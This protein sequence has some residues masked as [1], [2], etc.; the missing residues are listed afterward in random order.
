MLR[1]VLGRSGTG[2]TQYLNKL[3]T[4]FA[5]S[6][7]EKL[8]MIV[9]DQ[10]SFETEKSFLKS[11]GP[12]LCRNIKVLGFS[13]LCDYVFSE[14]GYKTAN[15]IDD[16]T[17][18]IIMSMAI[19]QVSDNLEL[20]SKQKSSLTELMT[21]SYR[22]CQKC[23][24]TADMLK[25]TAVTVPEQSLRQKL[26]ETALILEA[27]E[28]IIANTYIDPCENLNR[29]FEILCETPVFEDYI[30]AV[31]SFSGFTAQQYRVLECLM[32]NSADFYV[33]L[34]LE[35]ANH[36]TNS[37]FAITKE[38]RLKFTSIAEKLAVQIAPV[39]VLDKNY[40]IKSPELLH[41][42]NNLVLDKLDEYGE[43]P[44]D[45]SIVNAPDV[46]Q[47]ID[48]VANTINS[49]VM[50]E[51]L[52]YREIAVICHDSNAYST[53]IASAFEKNR[54]PCFMDY[55]EDIFIKPIVRLVCSCIKAVTNGFEREDVLTILKTGLTENTVEDISAFE[56]YLFTWNLNRKD[57]LSEF[58][59]NPDGLKG[60]FTQDDKDNLN[61]L[62]Q[63]RKSVIC[64]LVAFK[65]KSK[66]A[67]GEKITGNLYELLL[68]LKADK[69][70]IKMYESLE[71]SGKTELAAQQIR[72]WNILM[73]VLDKM[74]AVLNKFK[75]SLKRY[76]ELLSMQFENEK[77]SEIP[78][79]V[80]C[81]RFGDAQRIRLDSDTKAVFVIGFNRGE[82]PP[83]PSVTGVFT[84]TERKRLSLCQLPFRDSAE[85]IANHEK[86]L[87]Y[88]CLSSAS[89][90]LYIVFHSTDIS[91][92][93]AGPSDYVFS[94]LK[95]FP[96]I[97]IKETALLT[98]ESKLWSEQSAFD[99]CAQNYKSDSEFEKSLKNYFSAN[100]KYA[101]SLATINGIISNKPIKIMNP[102]IAQRLFGKTMNLSASR[103]EKYS[104]C[105]FQYFCT[106]GLKASLPRPAKIDA[107]EF[108]T[109]SH[110][111][112]EKFLKI[113]PK[114]VLPD[115]SDEK[116]TDD[117]KKIYIQYAKENL[118]GLGDKSN[119]FL[120]LYKRLEDNSFI[121]IKHLISE[122]SQS[123]FVPVDF[124]LEIGGDIPA[125]TVKL[126]QGRSVCIYGSVDRVDVMEKDGS[127][128]IRVIDYKTGV[129]EFS[130]TDIL[131]GINLQMLIYLCAIEKNGAERYGENTV[132][133]G[134]LYMYSTASPQNF[135][136]NT[137]E[138][139]IR[140]KLESKL[141][142]NGLVLNDIS[143]VE[144][145]DKSGSG[146]YIPVKVKSGLPY[147]SKSLVDLEQMG[148]IF[149]SIDKTIT[150]MAENLYSGNISAVPVKG[151]HHDGC[152]YC[153]YDSVC[154]Y[155]DGES[156][157]KFA[158]DL[159]DSDALKR[160]CK[161]PDPE[162][163]N[164]E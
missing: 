42:E 87:A 14:V 110:Y 128:Y 129:K 133:A 6:G 51:N 108:G 85:E 59:R 162:E 44:A 15:T 77:I 124:E 97:K 131:W 52:R 88:T 153:P 76:G 55:P 119:S 84:E 73:Q 41:L 30:I 102:E 142:M 68:N 138:D 156:P 78:Q 121:I 103:I 36:S 16:G 157:Y 154:N 137:D 18:K 114:E 111:V 95:M 115:L 118:G 134:I 101:D 107:L 100:P 53:L 99:Y 62:E 22:E 19:E 81:V 98:V 46:Y 37:V 96:K 48:Y 125:Y 147:S 7:S 9:P 71:S 94:L 89:Q 143:V 69:M 123:K 91:G 23:T 126:P 54:I 120:N 74:S 38:T 144:G 79:S 39:V 66:D 17:R 26:N 1:F 132:P 57:F 63:V 155:V 127:K 161:E 82:F 80:D 135:E 5:K 160:I 109:I 49:L 105:P 40:R 67:D 151:K 20:F 29:V 117:I 83:V 24:I 60:D 31:D 122:L 159:K 75:P 27:Y 149:K 34:N 43:T 10:S 8:L 12:K 25:N 61:A 47:E 72:L 163:D 58:T 152:Q 65:E 116:I 148:K 56:N 21:E 13:R 158:E 45:F 93:A 32:E 50:E 130:I 146:I 3:F 33:S 70:L 92:E 106:Y 90:K 2:K 145:M 104:L 64:P 112:F 140:E 113:N 4:D 11:A 139:K 136:I 35:A 164:N 86:F 141:K 28:A 150:D